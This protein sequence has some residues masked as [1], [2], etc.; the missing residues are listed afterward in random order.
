MVILDTTQGW[1]NRRAVAKL[2]YNNVL[3]KN[4]R[5]GLHDSIIHVMDEAGMNGISLRQTL[6]E[7]FEGLRKEGIGLGHID[8][9]LL[10][11]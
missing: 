10:P 9:D 2:L 7:L 1:E 3:D 6:E 4:A 11:E 8:E 5:L